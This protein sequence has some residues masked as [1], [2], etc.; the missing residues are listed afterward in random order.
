MSRSFSNTSQLTRGADGRPTPD[1]STYPRELEFNNTQSDSSG[2]QLAQTSASNTSGQQGNNN[3]GGHATSPPQSYGGGPASS[4]T[5]LS[6]QMAAYQQQ[7][8]GEAPWTTF[9]AG[10]SQS[11]GGSQGQGSAAGTSQG[12][13]QG[14]GYGGGNAAA[15]T[16]GYDNGYVDSMSAA[17]SQSGPG[18]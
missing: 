8:Q 2:S 18:R 15:G 4:N 10:P 9:S 12:G 5:H 14:G 13:A 3:Q 6:P 11:S 1:P 16:G 7:T 17:R